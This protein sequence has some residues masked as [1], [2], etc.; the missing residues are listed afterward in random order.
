M[1][2]TKGRF[3]SVL[4]SAHK[5]ERAW[6][7][8]QR[9]RGLAMAHGVKLVLPD[10]NPK[11]DW[12]PT[13]DAVAAVSLE[14]KVRSLTFTSPDDFPY[15][16]VFVDDLNGLS[17]ATPFAWVYISQSTGAWVWLSSLDRDESWEEQIVWDSMRGFNV[18]TLVAP[19]RF[20]RHADRLCELLFPA[21]SLQWVEGETG[22]FRG[23]EQPA[24]KCDPATRGRGR[25]APKDPG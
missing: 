10:H 24:D 13:P 2:W 6:V 18:P 17:R 14:I 9:G 8:T 16:T 7:E 11:K 20:L 19:S 22:G 3:L 21:E 5:A 23:E 1:A 25:K 12:C 4:Q 15:P